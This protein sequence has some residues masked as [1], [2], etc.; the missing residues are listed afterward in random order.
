[1]VYF[2]LQ[3][4][5]NLLKDV[6]VHLAKQEHLVCLRMSQCSDVRLVFALDV[7]TSAGSFKTMCGL[8][9]VA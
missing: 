4:S 7:L 8:S 9:W 5:S 6:N 1:M 3:Y 2:F